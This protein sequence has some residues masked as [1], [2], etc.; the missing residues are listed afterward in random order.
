M[1]NR[2]DFSGEADFCPIE[3]VATSRSGKFFFLQF[4]E[5]RT[6]GANIRQ[7]TYIL[8]EKDSRC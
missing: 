5:N 6:R 2:I 7:T 4:L 8:K 3:T 1:K